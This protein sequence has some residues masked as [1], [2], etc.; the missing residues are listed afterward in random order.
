MPAIN[1]YQHLVDVIADPPAAVGVFRKNVI[2]VA[3]L[4]TVSVSE[5][6]LQ[7]RAK[8]TD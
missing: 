5:F 2:G 4:E 1:P 6:L 7:D 8:V 3:D